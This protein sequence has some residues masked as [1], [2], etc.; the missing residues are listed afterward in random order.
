MRCPRLALGL[1]LLRLAEGQAQ[2]LPP[3]TLPSKLEV[4]AINGVSRPAD[5]RPVR[6]T[7]RTVAARFDTD[8]VQ[9][10]Q[11]IVTPSG[12]TGGGALFPPGG[13]AAVLVPFGSEDQSFEVRLCITAIAPSPV[14]TNP[15]RTFCGQG[16]PVALD[17]EAPTITVSAIEIDGVRTPVD[18]SSTVRVNGD[19]TL[20]GSV[21][22]NLT[23]PEELAVTVSM[24]GPPSPVT[25]DPS[26]LFEAAV[27]VAGLSD[28]SYELE[29]VAEDAMSDGTKPNRASL[30]MR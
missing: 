12:T 25:P 18:A 28:G 1:L 16:M 5:G 7:S 3:F 15:N 27:S 9:A 4:T 22:D 23:P 2:T 14:L 24:G 6:T 11:W 26:G 17:T 30:T 13:D 19:F 10:F 8:A 29:I 20:F 21:R